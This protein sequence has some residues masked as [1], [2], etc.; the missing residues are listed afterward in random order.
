MRKCHVRK[1]LAILT[2]CILTLSLFPLTATANPS[3]YWCGTHQKTGCTHCASHTMVNSTTVSA[4]CTNAGG[5]VRVCT[6]SGCGSTF[7]Q[8]PPLGHQYNSSGR[9]KKMCTRSTSCGNLSSATSSTF[10]HYMYRTTSLT[11]TY[12][13]NYISNGP[14]GHG[15]NNGIDIT[16]VTAG[17]IQGY[18]IYAQGNGTVLNA[19]GN[20]NVATGFYVEITYSNGWIVRYMHLENASSFNANDPVGLISQIGTTGNSGKSDTGASYGYH[21]HQDVRK[22]G[23][24][25]AYTNADTC[26]PSGT[27]D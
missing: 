20:A 22:N 10:Q 9:A 15:T 12:R 21:L 14:S 18:P 16:A 17:Q 7:F 5:T 26:Y 11:G 1:T 19:G 24:N 6:T 3:T 8:T 4:T 23:V 25:G 2:V 27:F 13:A